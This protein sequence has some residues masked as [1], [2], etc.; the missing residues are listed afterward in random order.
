VLF[1]SL[2]NNPNDYVGTLRNVP[3]KILIMFVHAY[4]SSLWNKAVAQYIYGKDLSVLKGKK[5]QVFG[6]GTEIED[7][8]INLIYEN[9]LKEEGISERSFVLREIPEI[10][11]EGDERIIVAEIKGLKVSELSEDELNEG[12][13]KCIVEFELGKGEYAT[14]A[15]RHMFGMQK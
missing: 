1:R 13:K 3:K 11:C 7:E 15:V 5:F 14:E 10:S 12:M 9:I 4:Q 6:F 2:E 8:E